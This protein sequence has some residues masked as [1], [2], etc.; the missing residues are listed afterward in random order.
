VLRERPINGAMNWR[1]LE[2]FFN[3][4]LLPLGIQSAFLITV[5]THIV[6]LSL[7]YLDKIKIDYDKRLAATG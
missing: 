5:K 1:Y 3:L 4:K 6:S 7:L 2:N